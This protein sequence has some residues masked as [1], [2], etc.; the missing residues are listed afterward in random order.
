MAVWRRPALPVGIDGGALGAGNLI[1]KDTPM[2]F[3][4]S[5]KDFLAYVHER[6]DGFVIEFQDVD[7]AIL[8]SIN[9]L[10]DLEATARAL[11]EGYLLLGT[12]NDN[13]PARLLTEGARP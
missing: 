13:K 10:E 7:K 12:A 2:I 5:H 6:D 4:I 11:L 8:A 3:F 1:L 9:D